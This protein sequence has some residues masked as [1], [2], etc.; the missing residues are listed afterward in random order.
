M[1]QFREE[2][3][4]GIVCH[5]DLGAHASHGASPNNTLKLYMFCISGE[6]FALL[7]TV[8]DQ[9]HME[10]LLNS[11][12]LLTSVD[13]C[14]N[15]GVSD[16]L[17]PELYASHF[18]GSIITLTMRLSLMQHMIETISKKWARAGRLGYY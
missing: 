5:H 4:N 1:K 9:V 13:E 15:L 18:M 8:L 14:N 6:H 10:A 17:L 3:F 11:D 2:V 12:A 7:Y 16:V